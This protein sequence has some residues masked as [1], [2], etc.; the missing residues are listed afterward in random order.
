MDKVVPRPQSR[1]GL[2]GCAAD[3]LRRLG[4]AGGDGGA[5]GPAGD[6][7]G[8]VGETPGA[9]RA[10]P[11]RRRDVPHSH[12][13]PTACAPAAVGTERSHACRRDRRAAR[14]VR[15]D[16]VEVRA[17]RG[18]DDHCTRHDLRHTA[19]T[20]APRLSNRLQRDLREFQW[21]DTRGTSP[22][23]PTNSINGLAG[24]HSL[25]FRR[26]TGRLPGSPLNRIG[27]V[28]LVARGP[29][30]SGCGSPQRPCQ[31]AQQMA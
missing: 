13:P 15:Q 21:T 27:S 14:R 31:A 4:G 11:R 1:I 10:S 26:E 2:H 22:A 30:R 7:V 24:L 29:T 16:G 8:G 20:W 18:R 6:A 23:T 28:R 17:G 3:R 9:A 5:A 12:S 25:R 19:I